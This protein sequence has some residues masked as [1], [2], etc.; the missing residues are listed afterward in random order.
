M[1]H[2]KSKILI[3]D[4]E[5]SVIQHLSAFLAKYD[6]AIA[7]AVTTGAEAIHQAELK[8]PDLVLMDIRLQGPMDGI[9]AG[10]KIHEEFDI[11]VIYLTAAFDAATL[12]RARVADPYGYVIKPFNERELV[13]TLQMALNHARVV[14]KHLENERWFDTTLK[15][16]GDAV[17][18]TDIDGYI[19]FLNPMAETLTGWPAAEAT[20][21]NLH[22]VL[23]LQEEL[24]RQAADLPDIHNL[25]NNHGN[26][27]TEEPTEVILVARDGRE[28]PV[29]YRMSII[30]DPQHQAIGMVMA[31][32]DLSHRHAIEKQIVAT[33]KMEAIGK[34]A[35]SIAHEFNSVL[36]LFNGYAS[37][38][39][40]HLIPN[41]RAHED[42]LKVLETV[43]HASVLTK[44]ILGVARA[45]T[46]DSEVK[47]AAIS[48]GDVIGSAV[49][50]CEKS[51]AERS[52]TIVVHNPARMPTVMADADQLL[53]IIMDLLMCTADTMADGG[54]IDLAV[55][56]KTISKPDPAA[57]PH[58]RPGRYAL[59]EVRNT[60]KSI[61]TEMLEH[62]FEPFF[63]NRGSGMRSGLGLSVAQ[64]SIQRFGGWIKVASKP[65]SGTTL[66]VHIPESSLPQGRATAKIQ[67]LNTRVL[68]V[69][70]H[71]DTLSDFA[72][73][74]ENA[75]YQVFSA[76]TVDDAQAILQKQGSAIDLA[77]I[78]VIIPGGDTHQLLKKMLEEY[79]DT[80]VI[81][82]CGFSREYVRSI[83][84][85]GPW[86]FLQKPAESEA[87]L[88]TV[89]RALAQRV[90]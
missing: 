84:S 10:R 16:I 89:T 39:L 64:V 62:L 74:L 34:M 30:R 75:G 60:A 44:R 6:Y 11:P 69:D 23:R 77:I 65:W 52:I 17:V 61:P 85:P 72:S 88:N 15:C 67:T 47:I 12:E 66:T 71:D 42:T 7:G 18:A 73:T 22:T 8:K 48:L 81:M 27:S 3:V 31:F 14:R 57:N 83:L 2:V 87:L 25:L 13:A 59:L 4:D 78:D 45:T 29:S 41:T 38:M 36:T 50:L 46:P 56:H 79:P 21:R 53:D 82:T 24:T 63:S 40:E 37:S 26:T 32:N 68:L 54:T 20:G 33:Q 58:A 19:T 43:R 55:T 5:S 86:L 90:T 49:T 35:S 9:E 76:G 28:Y 80:A 1:S 70:D 51:L